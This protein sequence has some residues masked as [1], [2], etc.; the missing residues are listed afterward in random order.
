VIQG[1]DRLAEGLVMAWPSFT[2]QGGEPLGAG[3][4]RLSLEAIDEA[5][6]VFYDGE[7]LFREAVHTGRKATKRIRALLRL[8]RSEVGDKVY[9]FENA[10]MRDTARLLS[11]VRTSAVLLNGAEDIRDLYAPILASGTF[12]ET[13]ERLTAQR[14]RIEQRAMED[15]DVVPRVV[16]NLERARQRYESWPADA[17]A[18]RVYGVGIRNDFRSIGPGLRETQA[19]GRVE[20]VAAYRAPSPESFHLWRKRAKYLK[21]QM[22]ILT[23]LWPE[24]M[25]GMALTLDRISEILGQ[26]HDLAELMRTLAHRPDICPN[27]LERSLLSALAEQRRSDLQTAARILGRRIY[28]E[29]PD[30][31]SAR[32]GSY[33]E[34][35][36]LART[37]TM[38][39]IPA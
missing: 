25:I 22:E 12:G 21:H 10:S 26:D 27:P 38:A 39:S 36:E 35:M 28:S 34:S 1:R 11:E 30:A 16:S 15:P 3:L 37:T 6:A 19:R 18:R 5:I 33:W 9:R 13:V 4:K 32:L 7:D 31:F 14:D 29:K 8:V 17:D 24:V 23:P 2:L 20:M